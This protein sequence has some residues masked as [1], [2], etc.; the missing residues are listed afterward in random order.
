MIS[1]VVTG[2]FIGIVCNY[3]KKLI[4]NNIDR[5]GLNLDDL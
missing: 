4:T 1:S 2:V 3:T 5:L